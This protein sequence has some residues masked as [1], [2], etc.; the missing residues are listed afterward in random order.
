MTPTEGI[1][2]LQ[3]ILGSLNVNGTK[4]T[5]AA[6]IADTTTGRGKPAGTQTHDQSLD[7]T[8]LSSAGGLV[9][10][11]SASSDVRLEKVTQLQAAI[12]SGTYK[13]SAHDVADK[14]IEGLLG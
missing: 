3:T 13:V 2:S 1:S 4:Q 10:Q 6:K 8:N 5:A 7:Q 12:A 14:I 11:A 9:A